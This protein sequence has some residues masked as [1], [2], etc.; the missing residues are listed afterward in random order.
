MKLPP[1]QEGDKEKATELILIYSEGMKTEPNYFKQFEA[2]IHAAYRNV[3]SV[4]VE[5]KGESTTK[6][7]NA[8]GEDV[9][10]EI[11]ARGR[12]RNV[13]VWLVYDKDDFSDFDEVPVVAEKANNDG[14]GA[15]YKLAWSNRCIELWFT[16][17]FQD[18]QRENTNKMPKISGYK[19][20]LEKHLGEIY[21]KSDNHIFGKLLEKG[22]P[23][24][25]ISRAEELVR[26]AESN[27]LRPSA[28][29]PCTHVHEL[30]KV[31]AKYLP[32][33]LKARFIG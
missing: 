32:D 2:S 8:I 28:S 12:R 19:R 13:T 22:D 30:V 15:V 31:L 17:H 23:K 7:F 24:T 26:Q 18:I 1:R 4:K 5:G 11:A 33:Q 10:R 9:G 3:V 21:K 6:L 14:S 16:L 20:K 25:A 29:D 27:G